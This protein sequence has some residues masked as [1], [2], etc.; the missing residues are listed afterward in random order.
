MSNGIYIH[1]PFCLA[2]CA[3]CDFNSYSGKM[4][5]RDDYITALISEMK[6]FSGIE[7][8]TVYIGGGTPTVL[9]NKQLERLI[10]AIHETFSLAE[11]TEF[12]VES[13]PATADFEKYSLL[14]NLG[15]N[16]LSIGVQSFRDNELK[17]LSRV[18][19]SA[20][21]IEAVLLAKKA[22][23]K[24]ISIDLME[25]I[26]NQTKDSLL[27][28]VKKA[29][30][31]PVNHISCYSLIIEEGTPFYD[32]TPPLPSDEEEREM[33]H[34]VCESLEKA[35]FTHYEIS[36]FGKDGAFSR[37]NMK[38]WT[39]EPY[40]GFGAGA[41]S[42]YG[43]VRYSNISG[44]EEYIKAEDKRLEAT[45]ISESEAEYERFMLG[46]RILTGF[47]TRGSFP[48]KLKALS[49]KGLI[50]FDGRIA[51]LTKRGEDLANL[52]FMEFLSE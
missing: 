6:S 38:Y 44:I 9:E 22:G 52:V 2:K 34:A 5:L 41:H 39:G 1:I 17:A 16:R 42:Y 48:D 19:S 31:L 30:E 12:S 10:T 28:N 18:H 35:G 50:S 23:F 49:E 7:A 51:K 36:N 3:Y 46:F 29:L 24:N 27:E 47:E 15:V 20:D 11:D 45:E 21:A 8:D 32:N 40:Y 4:N 43:N 26:P 37:H 14:K 25:A 33:H 13:N